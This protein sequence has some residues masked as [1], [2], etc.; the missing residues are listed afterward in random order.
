MTNTRLLCER[1]L[2]SGLKRGFIAESLGITRTALSYKI[3]NHS[4]F[5]A[6]EITAL[7]KL[8]GIDDPEERDT[9]FFAEV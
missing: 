6:S 3:N 1:I 4:E 7:C 2:K 8:L 9:I 5:R